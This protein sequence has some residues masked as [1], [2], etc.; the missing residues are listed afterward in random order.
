[1]NNFQCVYFVFSISLGYPFNTWLCKFQ[2]LIEKY[3]LHVKL[4]NKNVER[5]EWIQICTRNMQNMIFGCR[6]H[7]NLIRNVLNYVNQCK[8][9]ANL[10]VALSLLQME[11]RLKVKRSTFFSLGRITYSWFGL[12]NVDMFLL[13]CSMDVCLNG[14]NLLRESHNCTIINVDELRLPY[15]RH[16]SLAERIMRR[17][18]YNLWWC[19]GCWGICHIRLYIMRTWKNGFDF[20]LLS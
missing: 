13:S 17:W 7:M 5:F 4:S 12:N 15:I 9:Q 2:K 16:C 18:C 14:K 8:K 19:F 1:M 20:F 10:W 6:N 11:S 3:N